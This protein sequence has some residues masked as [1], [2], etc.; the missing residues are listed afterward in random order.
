[1]HGKG[2]FS[3]L[4]TF[5]AAAVYSIAH[6][7]FAERLYSARL[8]G[9]P[10]ACYAPRWRGARPPASQPPGARAARPH[11][12]QSATLRTA[13]VAA[14]GEGEG[15]SATPETATGEPEAGEVEANRAGRP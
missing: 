13:A 1:M 11:E 9:I 2:S 10:N 3:K 8:S 6:A 5:F 7:I 14:A 4:S 15:R 12:E